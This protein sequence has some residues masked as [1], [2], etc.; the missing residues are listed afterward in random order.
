MGSRDW[1]PPAG[2]ANTAGLRL[3]V[4]RSGVRI[5]PARRYEAPAPAG[6]PPL[7]ESV[8]VALHNDEGVGLPSTS[9]S[10]EDGSATDQKAPNGGR[11]RTVRGTRRSAILTARCGVRRRQR[12]SSP[13]RTALPSHPWCWGFSGSSC[14]ASAGS[15]RSCS[16]MSPRVRFVGPAAAK[17][18]AV[19]AVAGLTLGYLQ[20]VGGLVLAVALVTLVSSRN[21]RNDE[22][23]T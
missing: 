13:P 21:V 11:Q 20:L 9:S 7:S 12:R 3:G 17:G 14:G 19:S 5:S 4:K 18:V 16:V 2:P 8:A 6:V 10:G 22:R 23:N 15:W 1:G